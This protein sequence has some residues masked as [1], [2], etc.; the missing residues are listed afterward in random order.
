MK[1]N[2]TDQL[3]LIFT[4]EMKFVTYELVCMYFYA[5]KSRAYVYNRLRS[6]VQDGFLF[7][8]DWH[9][10]D[11]IIGV[12]SDAFRITPKGVDAI[13]YQNEERKYFMKDCDINNS[14]YAID[15][16]EPKE[17]INLA[18]LGHDFRLMHFRLKFMRHEYQSDITYSLSYLS[19]WRIYN[20]N[21]RHKLKRRPDA[22]IQLNL[23]GKDFNIAIEYEHTLKSTDALYVHLYYSYTGERDLNRRNF[24]LRY[25]KKES[26]IYENQNKFDLVVFICN[27]DNR[28]YKAF[29]KIESSQSVPV[30]AWSEVKDMI[31]E[32][33]IAWA[34]SR[35]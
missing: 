24:K 29:K 26:A 23:Q 7:R 19:D 14:L 1:L 25:S 32:E 28:T 33:F 18:E 16:I 22:I 2:P 3:I 11:S 5:S 6:M 35:I 4:L 12:C 10:Y 13:D 27:D 9:L 30:I 34:K 8:W 31:G 21:Y 17:H 20:T 15:P